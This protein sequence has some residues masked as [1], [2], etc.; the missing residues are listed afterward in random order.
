MI[1]GSSSRPPSAGLE[2]R[3]G[4]STLPGTEKPF[5]FTSPSPRVRL[6]HAFERPF[7]NVV[8]TARTCYSAKGIVTEEQ[9]S[10]KP[11]RRDTLAKS[12]Y[13]AGH[14]TTFQHA[15]FQFAL[16][17]KGNEFDRVARWAI[18][19]IQGI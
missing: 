13:A 9:A 15:H 1:L 4:M 12:I 7:E 11:K 17:S 3:H 16:E 14:H 8:A 5:R 2:W 6:V 19:P 10:A 18:H